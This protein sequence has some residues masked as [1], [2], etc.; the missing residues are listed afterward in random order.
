MF[1]TKTTDE[2]KKINWT[3]VKN[4]I[5]ACVKNA[6]LSMLISLGFFTAYAF[7]WAKLGFSYNISAMVLLALQAIISMHLFL[8]SLKK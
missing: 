8:K 3:A 2:T 7:I 6:L 1:K 5:I 4:E